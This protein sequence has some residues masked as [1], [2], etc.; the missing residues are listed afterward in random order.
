MIQGGDFTAGDGTGGGIP[1]NPFLCL[2]SNIHFIWPCKLHTPRLLLIQML[3]LFKKPKYIH[4]Y[5]VG[6]T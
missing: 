4:I 2:L 6:L 5:G 3:T 1:L